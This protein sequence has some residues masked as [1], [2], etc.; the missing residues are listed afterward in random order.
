MTQKLR[1]ALPVLMLLIGVG[2]GVPAGFAQSKG[3]AKKKPAASNATVSGGLKA[4]KA[5]IRKASPKSASAKAGASTSP[6]RSSK[7]ASTRARRQ[8]GQKAP[9]S[10]R[11]GEIQAALAKD[12]SFAG[13]PSGKWDEET[14]VA[15]RKFQSAHGLNPS[16]KLDA[17]TL[18]RLGLGSETAGIAAPIAPPGAISRLT[19]SAM[20]P[21]A[22]ASGRP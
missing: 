13:T 21:T 9:T 15:M 14:A 4:S 6:S 2:L 12:G 22:E 8:P 16:G 10:E 11:I 20:A 3:P 18:Q 5:P 1:P 7:R 17:L 19:S